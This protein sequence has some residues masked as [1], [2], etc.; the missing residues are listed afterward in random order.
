MNYS[1]YEDHSSDNG[2]ECYDDDTY[3]ITELEISEEE[4]ETDIILIV[5]N[6]IDHIVKRIEINAHKEQ[7]PNPVQQNQYLYEP[8]YDAPYQVLYI[9]EP[10]E[11][12]ERRHS[13]TFAEESENII[14][15]N[16]AADDFVIKPIIPKYW[17]S[18]QRLRS[19]LIWEQNV[20]FKSVQEIQAQRKQKSAPEIEVIKLKIAEDNRIKKK[21]KRQRLKLHK[22][23]VKANPPKVNKKRHGFQ[24]KGPNKSPKT[25]NS[26]PIT[27]SHTNSTQE[28]DKETTN[29]LKTKKKRHGF[30][31]KGSNKRSKTRSSNPPNRNNTQGEF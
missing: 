22:A 30:Q 7:Y 28:K 23:Q 26:N 31:N 14:T 24:N 18:W 16:Y 27:A 4:D 5:G 10:R 21:G 6:I 8:P 29:Q 19:N 9:C 15:L 20:H 13:I 12:P 25:N 17:Y 11:P 3:G 1:E 2:E